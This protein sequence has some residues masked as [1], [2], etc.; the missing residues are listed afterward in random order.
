MQ[1][2]FSQFDYVTSN[3]HGSPV[4]YASYF[5]AKVSVCGPK[6]KWDRS[7]RTDIFFRN[8]PELLDHFELW[9]ST[10]FLDKAYRQINL[11]PHLA[12]QNLA[13][14]CYELRGAM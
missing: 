12:T 6:P 3:G 10:D 1:T 13:W 14:A 9:R 7:A 11:E 5:G 8:A 4:A 2:V